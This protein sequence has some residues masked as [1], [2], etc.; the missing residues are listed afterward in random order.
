MQ[1]P[2]LTVRETALFSAHLWL[3][4]KVENREMDE[5]KVHYVDMVLRK[6]KLT[7]LA[8]CSVGSDDEDG[9]SFEVRKWSG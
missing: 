1:A 6:L 7:K 3:N 5:S 9:L 2:E 8:D 4:P